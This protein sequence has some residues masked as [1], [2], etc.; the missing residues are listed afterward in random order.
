MGKVRT[1]RE[2]DVFIARVVK[3]SKR[4]GAVLGAAG[5]LLTP[6]IVMWLQV[7]DARDQTSKVKKQQDVGYEM[8][9]MPALKELQLK[10]GE[11]QEWA[12]AINKYLDDLDNERGEL[13]DRILRLE[14]IIE[15][16]Y[17]HIHPPEAPE[18]VAATEPSEPWHR[19][20]GLTEDP[21]QPERKAKAS[22]GRP[23]VKLYDDLATAQQQL[24]E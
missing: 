10:A 11:E 12:G 2:R 24:A 18:A 14:T 13:H 15:M 19:A 6:M 9:V 8:M 7:A 17:P 23:A 22:K 21:D 5:A 20:M 1:Q 4:I 16:K 3:W